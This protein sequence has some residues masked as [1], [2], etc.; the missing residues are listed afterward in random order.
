MSKKTAKKMKVHKKTRKYKG[1]SWWNP[2]STSTNVA[3]V[4]QPSGWSFFGKPSA[5]V[6]PPAPVLDPAPSQ[7]SFSMSQTPTK[8][9]RKSRKSK[10]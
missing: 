5:P 1:G 10:K 3:T 7:S 4:Q 8:A 6:A 9:G 2:F